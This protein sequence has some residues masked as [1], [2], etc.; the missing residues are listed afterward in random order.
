MSFVKN[1]LKKSIE[2]CCNYYSRDSAFFFPSAFSKVDFEIVLAFFFNFATK[3][4]KLLGSFVYC[5][6]YF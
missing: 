5:L 2:Q 6:H 4:N 3:V 1:F